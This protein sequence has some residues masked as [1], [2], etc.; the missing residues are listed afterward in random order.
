MLNRGST[1][2]L[3]WSAGTTHLHTVHDAVGIL[4]CAAT[5]HIVSLMFTRTPRFFLQICF[6]AG[7]VQELGVIPLQLQDFLLER[8]NTLLSPVFHPIKIPLNGSMTLQ[9]IRHFSVLYYLQTHCWNALVQWN[10]LFHWSGHFKAYCAQY[11]PPG[12]TSIN[13]WGTLLVTLRWRRQEAP[14]PLWHS[15]ADSAAHRQHGWGTGRAG[16][17]TC[18]CR[19]RHH[20][21]LKL[22]GRAQC[23]RG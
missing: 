3:S 9:H 16:P 12:G 23:S 22:G 21:M 8:Y 15:G 2:H 20:L 6:P 17:G 11:Q 18:C 14:Q 5:L 13:P 19:H 4:F 10:T 7:H 1:D